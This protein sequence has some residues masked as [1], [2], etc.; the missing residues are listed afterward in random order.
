MGTQTTIWAIDVAE[1]SSPLAEVDGF[2]ISD[3]F[4]PPSNWLPKNITLRLQDVFSSFPDELL[5][6]Y[7]VV[8]F[9]LFLTLSTSRLS[10]A[11]E[12]AVKLLK[13]GGYIQ[14]T[15][16][17]KTNLKPIA[18][19]PELST[20]AVK[21]LINLEQNPF[22]NYNASWVLEIAPTMAS[23]GLEI[24]AEDRFQT[25]R[26][27]L[28]QMNELHLLAMMD[29]PAGLSKPVDEFKEKYLED[30]AEENQK[31]VSSID[32]FICVVGRKPI[33]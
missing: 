22:P 9:R 21:A 29:I 27:M 10:Q 8:H 18:K 23:L 28:T 31:G 2:D 5:G 30:L 4:F 14:W 13:P 6:K 3:K 20:E 1:N 12:N 25:K 32:G 16:H 24:I 26:S 33:S 11:L 7:D 15:E 17:D 19:S